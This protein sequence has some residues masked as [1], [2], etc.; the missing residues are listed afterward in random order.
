MPRRKHRTRNT[1]RINHRKT[2]LTNVHKSRM[3]GTVPSRI[4]ETC[5]STLACLLLSCHVNNTGRRLHIQSTVGQNQSQA[6]LP[7]QRL[8]PEAKPAGDPTL[9]LLSLSYNGLIKR[10]NL[11]ICLLAQLLH[12]VDRLA[13]QVINLGVSLGHLCG[14]LGISLVEFGFGGVDLCRSASVERVWELQLT[15]LSSFAPV[16]LAHTSPCFL[17]SLLE[18]GRSDFTLAEALA[19]SSGTFSA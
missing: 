8:F 16:S 13:L 18:P 15:V 7:P 12:L 17:A 5:S 14:K 10:V 11:L 1:V 3:F 9:C 4:V 2:Q 19:A 6:K